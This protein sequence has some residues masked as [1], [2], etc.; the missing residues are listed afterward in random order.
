MSMTFESFHPGGGTLQ[1]LMEDMVVK[2][3][4]KLPMM[5][6]SKYTIQAQKVILYTLITQAILTSLVW[7]E[8]C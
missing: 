7:F 4:S 5:K 1:F 6:S 3:G 8:L 2:R